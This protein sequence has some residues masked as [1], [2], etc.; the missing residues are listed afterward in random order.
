MALPQTQAEEEKKPIQVLFTNVNI[1]DGFSDTLQTGMS[2]L[3][4][5]NY[6]KEVAKT[7][8]KPEG[9]YV[10]DGGGRTMTPGLIDMHQHVMLNPPEG[11]ASYQTQWDDA[12]GGAFAQH[13]LVN[14]MLLKGITTIRDIAG[15]PLDVAKAIDMGYLP[16][17][18]IY[19]S[20][21]AIS[22]VGGHGDWAGRNVPPELLTDKMDMT[23]RTQNS[24][25][26]TGPD[27]VTRAVRLNL[28]R[29]AAFTKVMG[30]GGV[31]SEFDPLEIMGLAADEVARAVEISADNGTYVATHAY[32]DTSYNRLLDLGVRS[33]EH[34]FLISEPTVKRMKK[35]Q[36]E[37][38]EIVWSF[39]C[40]MSINSFG[41][42]ESMPEFFTHEQKVKGVAVGKG[43]RQAAKMMNEHDV[44][45]VGGSDMFSPGLVERIKEDLT[46][47]VK[48]GGI[49]LK[50]S[51]PKDPYP[52]YELGTIKEGAYADL[53]LW[54]GN[55]LE[56][57][58]LILNEEKLVFIMKDGLTYKNTMVGVDS[59]IYR[60]V[61]TPLTRGQFPL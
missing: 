51:G 14:N 53:L 31:A 45:T 1:F 49:V 52:T 50:W 30:G 55:P 60:P 36:D 27:E 19:S 58:E 12:A 11:T 24:W 26:V 42:Y 5:N 10:V 43:A 34:G 23:Q 46:C 15:D 33:F 41:S 57:I 28:R 17:P 38:K 22:Q 6:I 48:A 39:Q 44:F 29:G 25:S 3:V 61:K 56:N 21:G 9:A 4:E 18:R 20:G 54:D 7:I 32:H 2:V 47:N 13:H 37:G 59:P 40:F 8:T 35:M 16:G